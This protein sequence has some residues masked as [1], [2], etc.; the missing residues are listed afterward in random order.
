MLMHNVKVNYT[1]LCPGCALSAII[2]LFR[3]NDSAR[4]EVS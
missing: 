3:Y 4:E 1:K 2:C